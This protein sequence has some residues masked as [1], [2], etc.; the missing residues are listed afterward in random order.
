MLGFQPKRCYKIL[1]VTLS[2]AIYTRGLN[3]FFPVFGIS[4]LM[5]ETVRAFPIIY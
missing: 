3:M 1:K 2:L 4:L 5:S